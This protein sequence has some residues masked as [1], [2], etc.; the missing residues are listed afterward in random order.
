MTNHSMGEEVAGV[1][2]RCLVM[3]YCCQSSFV[4]FHTCNC[5]HTCTL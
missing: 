3:C 5:I 4:S 2:E 1:G